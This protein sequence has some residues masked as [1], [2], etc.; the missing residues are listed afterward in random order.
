[1]KPLETP[2]DILLSTWDF[3]ASA[4]VKNNLN[5]GTLLWEWIFTNTNWLEFALTFNQYSPVLIGHNLSA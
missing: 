3:L 1:M 2:V 5:A 4:D